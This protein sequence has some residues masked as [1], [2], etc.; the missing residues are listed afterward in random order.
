MPGDAPIHGTG[1]RAGDPASP[2]QACPASATASPSPLFSSIRSDTNQN[3]VETLGHPLLKLKDFLAVNPA[4]CESSVRSLSPSLPGGRAIFY[5]SEH[6]A[7]GYLNGAR[8]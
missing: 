6:Q 1:S 5:K 7:Q 2:P 8:R 3:V 4:N